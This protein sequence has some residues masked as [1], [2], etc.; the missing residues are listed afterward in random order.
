MRY[1]EL[2]Y[3]HY[4]SSPALSWDVMLKI[5]NVKLELISDLTS[6][7]LLKKD[8]E[9][10]IH[11]FL[12]DIVKVIIKACFLMTKLKHIIYKDTNHLCGDAKFS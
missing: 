8:S 6:I 12:K 3:A 2:N 1:Y 9:V 7:N 11:T 10:V 4:L 5:T